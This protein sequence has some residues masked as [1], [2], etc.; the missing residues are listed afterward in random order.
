MSKQRKP[1]HWTD[2]EWASPARYVKGW[3]INDAWRRLDNAELLYWSILP[4]P[5]KQGLAAS[6]VRFSGLG[7]KALALIVDNWASFLLGSPSD[8]QGPIVK[9]FADPDP[10][11]DVTNPE[12]PDEANTTAQLF[13][14]WY[15]FIRA[16]GWNAADYYNEQAKPGSEPIDRDEVA[17]DTLALFWARKRDELDTLPIDKDEAKALVGTIA[18]RLAR[19]VLGTD[20]IPPQSIID[21][22]RF[23]PAG[24]VVKLDDETME[25]L[26][27][28]YDKDKAQ[29]R[30]IT[31]FVAH[32]PIGPQRDVAT[33]L[34]KGLYPA[35]IATLLKVGS[36][37]VAKT[38][39]RIYAAQSRIDADS[40]LRALSID[41]AQ[42]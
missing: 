40:I 1:E 5:K 38:M 2:E 42:H 14:D 34:S 21:K 18:G 11:D 32:L 15:R 31:D 33:M 17:Q 35:Q 7:F 4:K 27:Y 9:P 20:K 10:N 8:K 19:S 13:S 41:P 24:L 12:L 3:I 6:M 39:H 36:S 37:A 29:G 23:L 16:C 26:T 22:G 28:C 25:Y 30:D